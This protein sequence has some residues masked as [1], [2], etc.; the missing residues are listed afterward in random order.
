MKNTRP[1]SDADALQSRLAAR[2]VAG[3]SEQ[4]TALPH[5]ITERLRVA[6]E[7]AVVRARDLR[8]KAPVLAPVLAPAFAGFSGAAIRL[9]GPTPW[10]QRMASVL[11]LLVLLVGLLMIDQWSAREQMMAAA[12]IDTVLLADDLPP[13]AYSDPGFAEF[14][15]TPAP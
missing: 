13:A 15:N 11:P 4:A 6:R 5:D 2:L 3:L 1:Y 10:W 7:Q 12:D 9:G 8:T 14:L